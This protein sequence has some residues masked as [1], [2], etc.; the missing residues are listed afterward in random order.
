MILQQLNVDDLI[1]VQ[2]ILGQNYLDYNR[3]DES[4]SEPS[5]ITSR[6]SEA[7]SSRLLKDLVETSDTGTQLNELIPDA[8]QELEAETDEIFEDEDEDNEGAYCY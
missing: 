6:C 7:F 2:P 4:D 8:K 3:K 1:F 5:D